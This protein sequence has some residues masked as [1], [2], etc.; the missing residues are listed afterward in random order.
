MNLNKLPRLD[1]ISAYFIRLASDII[2]NPLSILCNLSFSA[3]VYPNCIKN[4]KAIPLFKAGSKSELSN[5]RSISL[6]SCL[7]KMKKLIYSRLIN[8]LNK[9]SIFHHNQHGFRSGLFTSHALLDVMTTAY[10][11]INKML[12]TPLIYFDSCFDYKKTFDIA[13][14]KILLSKLE[15]YGI[16]GQLSI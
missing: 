11:N 1:G 5:Y 14:H 16:H 9:N 15:H 12:Y 13:R 8:Y 6:L 10:D 7:S 2:A 4:A 3:G